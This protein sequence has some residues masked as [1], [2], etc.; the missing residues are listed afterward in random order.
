MSKEPHGSGILDKYPYAAKTDV[1]GRLVCILDARSEERGMQLTIHPSRA[2]CQGEIH[3]L[4]ITDDPQAGPNYTLNR[5][6]YL[7]FFA[8]E[9][10]GIVLAGDRVLVGEVEL[11][12]VVGF[13][14]THFPNHMNLLI[15]ATERKTG[16]ELGLSLGDVVTFTAT[17]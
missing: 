5:V 14:L 17:L 15:S 7:A 10:G 13:D 8:V 11:G 4:A 12:S 1:V 16:L 3:E 9:Q 6:A 2:A